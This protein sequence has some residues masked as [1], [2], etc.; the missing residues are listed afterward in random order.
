MTTPKDATKQQL[1]LESNG[2]LYCRKCQ[3]Y[4]R[5]QDGES[6]DD[7]VSCECGWELEFIESLPTQSSDH[8][9]GFD[10]LDDTEEIEQLLTLLKSKSAKRKAIIKNLSNHI[11]IQEELLNEIKEERWTVWDVLNERNLQADIKNQKRLLDDISDNEDRL[12]SI[13]REQRTK[14]YESE[15]LTFTGFLKTPLFIIL[16]VIVVVVVLLFLFI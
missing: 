14:A 1:P 10:E 5:L 9:S 6:K 2:Y 4:Y 11:H 13:V 12:M 8:Y 7:F 15:K 16:V 3:G